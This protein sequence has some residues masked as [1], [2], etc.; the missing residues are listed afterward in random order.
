MLTGY[1]SNMYLGGKGDSRGGKWLV[2]LVFVQNLQNDH[3]LVFIFYKMYL[4]KGPSPASHV[5]PVLQVHLPTHQ[6]QK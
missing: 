1:C 4:V 3:P 5:L 6:P 2:D